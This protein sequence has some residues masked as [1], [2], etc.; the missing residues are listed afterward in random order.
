M[1]AA[2][3]EFGY[4]ITDEEGAELF[5]V[6]DTERQGRLGRAE[7]SAGLIDWKAFQVGAGAL[8]LPYMYISSRVMT[9]G[10]CSA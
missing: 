5:G 9:G 6:V 8:Q 4:R 3:K 1:T 2:L 7:L 10:T